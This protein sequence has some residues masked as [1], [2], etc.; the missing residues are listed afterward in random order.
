MI[1]FIRTKQGFL[2][3]LRQD[4]VHYDIFEYKEALTHAPNISAYITFRIKLVEPNSVK[5]IKPTSKEFVK[6]L[7]KTVSKKIQAKRFGNRLLL[8]HGK[9]QHQEATPSKSLQHRSLEA[10]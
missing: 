8:N 3:F 6:T 1:D 4:F 9:P 2:D 10:S 5:S 7:S